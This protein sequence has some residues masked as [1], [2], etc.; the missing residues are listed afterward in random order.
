MKWTD[1]SHSWVTWHFASLKVLWEHSEKDFLV[2]WDKN[3]TLWPNSQVF[4][5]ARLIP[6]LLWNMDIADWWLERTEDTWKEHKQHQ[7]WQR[8]TVLYKSNH[9]AKITWAGMGHWPSANEWPS[10]MLDWKL[11]MRQ[12]DHSSLMSSIYS[13][14]LKGRNHL[15][16]M[17]V[18]KVSGGRPRTLE[19]HA[20]ACMH[21]RTPTHPHEKWVRIKPVGSLAV[22]LT[23]VLVVLCFSSQLKLTLTAL[24]KKPVCLDYKRQTKYTHLNTDR[25]TYQGI[26]NIKCLI[27]DSNMSSK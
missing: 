13:D 4:F 21:V 5:I 15:R 2:G 10:Q 24:L 20:H 7:D 6:C 19:A 17:K 22:V 18:S 27:F 16:Q 12:K 9:S 25:D 14:S 11:P 1:R 8:L 26:M 23:V 3:G